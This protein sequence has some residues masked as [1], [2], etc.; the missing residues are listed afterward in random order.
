MESSGQKEVDW[1]ND[2]RDD[3]DGQR[4]HS[5]EGLFGASGICEIPTDAV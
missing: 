5:P 1:C 3:C 4:H 2:E